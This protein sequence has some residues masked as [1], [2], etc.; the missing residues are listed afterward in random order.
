MLYER[1]VLISFRYEIENRSHCLMI[2]LRMV[3]DL[4]S[5]LFVMSKLSCNWYARSVKFAIFYMNF[6]LPYDR[7]MD[8][9]YKFSY[10]I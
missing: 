4:V 1:L 5:Y 7:F 3:K 6:Y 8:F 10:D 9:C 2:S